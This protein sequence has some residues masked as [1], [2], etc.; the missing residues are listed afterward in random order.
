MTPLAKLNPKWCGL[1]RPDSGEGITFD[2]PKCGPSHRLCVYFDN[3]LDDKPSASWQKPTWKREGESFESLTIAPSIQYQCFHG[4][5][6]E[7][8]VIGISESPMRVHMHVNGVQQLVA[9]SPR[10]AKEFR[11]S[12]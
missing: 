5:V 6:E 9:L 10:Q 1:L 2:C 11:E 3:P 7:G 4:W 8:N 12:R